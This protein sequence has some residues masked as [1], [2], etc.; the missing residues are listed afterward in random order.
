M[1]RDSGSDRERQSATHGSP[2]APATWAGDRPAFL[3][4]APSCW[5]PSPPGWLAGSAK[6]RPG[7]GR[8]PGVGSC[9][10]TKE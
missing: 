5:L 8:R 9:L 6:G 2:R 4:A 7:A 10:S 1:C 3:A